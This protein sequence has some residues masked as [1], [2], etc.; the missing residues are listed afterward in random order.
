[1]KAKMSIARYTPYGYAL[2]IPGSLT[3]FNGECVLEPLEQ[4]F[5][6]AGY[7][8][9]SPSL[10]RFFSVDMKSPFEEGG[11]NAYS[12]CA[13]DPVNRIDP[14]GQSWRSV[15][16][17]IGKRLGLR[18]GTRQPRPS[19][20]PLA[21]RTTSEPAIA[22]AANEPSPPSYTE[23]F[24]KFPKPTKRAIR[25]THTKIENLEVELDIAER[26]NDRTAPFL[27]Q[28]LKHQIK[29]RDRLWSQPVPEPLP[30]YGELFPNETAPSQTSV[31][32]RMRTVR[33]AE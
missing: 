4:Y 19:P 10:M 8:L 11:F 23:T 25:K 7:R 31:G 16:K 18:S 12:Y 6:G 22:L 13:G 9:Y 20:M 29:K 27:A 2:P 5:L 28:D 32:S 3:G 30:A 26:M 1:M 17:G 21:Q 15:F 33:F 24:S 14:T